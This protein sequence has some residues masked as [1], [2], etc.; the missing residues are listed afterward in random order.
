[1]SSKTTSTDAHEAACR[2]VDSRYGVPG[3]TA[4]E[5]ALCEEYFSTRD[6]LYE[7]PAKTGDGLA[8]KLRVLIEER[9]DVFDE[10]EAMAVPLI[11]AD[12]ERL[13]SVS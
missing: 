6:R 11:L 1:M 2:A 13:G 8:A 4:R 12:A 7:T 10:F 3:L 9:A 5:R